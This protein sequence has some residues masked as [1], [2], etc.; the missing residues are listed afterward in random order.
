M[1]AVEHARLIRSQLEVILPKLSKIKDVRQTKKIK[2]SLAV[3]MLY[4][5]LIFVHQFASR[6]E[7]NAEI[8]RP[9]F[10]HN[11]RRLF[12]E[13]DSLPHADTLY[14]LLCKIDVNQIE[15]AHTDLV[16]RLIRKKKFASYLIDKGYPIAIDGTQKLSNC[17]F[18]S[19][20]LQQRRVATATGE[21]SS[22]PVYQYYVY[23]LEANLCFHNGMVIPLMSEFLDYQ[24]G[25]SEQSKQDC[26]Q[27]AFHR[28]AERIK[29][30]FPKLSIMLL[31]DGLY[32]TAPVMKRCRD[33]NWGLMIVLKDGSLPSVWGEYHGLLKLLPKQEYRQN[34]GMRKQIFRW[35]NNIRYEYGNNARQYMELHV[36]VCHEE[37]KA[38]DEKGEIVTKTAKHAWISSRKLNSDNIHQRCNLGARHRWGI[39]TCN[40][41][42]KHQG[43]QYEHTFA[44]N[45]NAMRGYHY[46]MRLAHLLN[47][48]ARFS[49]ALAK[50]H[51][52]LGVRGFIKF[53]RG[54]LSGPWFDSTGVES[55]QQRMREPFQL[56]LT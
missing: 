36:V 16:R 26:E 2:Y 3:L 52:E 17:Q 48:L 24:Q 47:T 20:S 55:L 9:M 53:L 25:D 42:E 37:W 56:R 30:A 32:P 54:T 10:E 46:L 15:Q 21:E 44:Q 7:A 45:W 39:E 35:V 12:P 41:V 14:R 50:Q 51:L 22:E 5:I 49:S 13:L 40:L 43:Y 19:D 29:Q 38:V 1:A 4:G 34:W 31:L 28:L 8:T 27:K 6:R 33:Y 23:V 18:F 11:L